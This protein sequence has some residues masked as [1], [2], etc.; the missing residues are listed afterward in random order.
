MRCKIAPMN[1]TKYEQATFGSND[2][3]RPPE[4]RTIGWRIVGLPPGQGA[5]VSEMHGRWQILRI[6]DGVHGEW[7]GEFA[8]DDDAVAA[9][10][11]EIQ[12]ERLARP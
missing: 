5:L 2:L 12:S 9:L 6:V 3:G 1:L 10:Q 7:Y 11:R 8:T 4:R